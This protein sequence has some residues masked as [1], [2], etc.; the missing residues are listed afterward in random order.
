[1]AS[2][3]AIGE[4]TAAWKARGGGQMTVA[5]RT[6]T[7]GVSSATRRQ[8]SSLFAEAKKIYE[9]GGGYMAGT[10][11]GIARGSKRAV[12]SGVQQ[13]ASAGLAGT[14]IV[15]GLGKKYEEEIGM[16]IRQQATTA[17]LGALAGLL[18]AEAG[19]TASLATRYSTSPVSYGGGGGGGGGGTGAYGYGGAGGAGAG[20]AAPGGTPSTG[21]GTNLVDYFI[22][23]MEEAN[24]ANQARYEEGLGLLEQSAGL[25]AP[26]GGFG[27]GA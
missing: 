7:S 13:L 4:S 14:S 25:Y 12:A 1:M 22:K 21:A 23:A 9:P 19:A 18:Q 27:A 15:G 17:R 2:R 10:E 3:Q 24:Q 16:P 5:S 20:G 26:G 11:A 6:S 8:V